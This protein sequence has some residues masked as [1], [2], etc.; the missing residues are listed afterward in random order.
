[1]GEP[2]PR[3]AGPGPGRGRATRAAGGAGGPAPCEPA[4]P[5]A[6]CPLA[7]AAGAVD[8]EGAPPG[9]PGA[10]AAAMRVNEKYSTLPAEDRSV[11]IINICAIEDIG[12]LPSEGTVSAGGRQPRSPGRAAHLRRARGGR[13]GRR[14]VR[15]A[16][17]AWGAPSGARGPRRRHAPTHLGPE[18]P[19]AAASP[20][21]RARARG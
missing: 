16:L 9:G 15:R 6:A 21:A 18:T 13:D 11:H 12:Y 4:R 17:G 5:N 7:E 14:W 20:P 19:P 8:G 1:M 2:A 10:Q 3:R